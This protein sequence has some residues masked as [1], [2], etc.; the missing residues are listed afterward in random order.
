MKLKLKDTKSVLVLGI[1]GGLAQLTAK[2][3]RDRY[4][5]AKIMGVDARPIE[6]IE[7]D[8]MTFRTMRFTRTNL[9]RLFRQESFD[10]LIV[11]GRM[12]LAKLGSK[13][14]SHVDENMTGISTILDLALEFSVK[15]LV[16]LSTFHVYGAYCDNT[17]FLSE[18]S[19]LR[20][21]IRFPELRDVVAVDHMITSW[22]WKHKKDVDTIL[23]RPCSIIGPNIRNIMS[24][25]LV[26]SMAPA[27]IDYNPLFQ[28]IHEDDM[29]SVICEATRKLPT[30]IYN[31]APPK[32]ITL[33]EAR[34]IMN[35]Q[36][37]PIPVSIVSQFAK[38]LPDQILRIPPY[39]LQYT[40]YQS[41]LDRSALNEFLPEN[42]FKFTSRSALEDYC[43]TSHK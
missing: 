8:D 31:V 17:V 4:P 14:E 3:V 13:R 39:L 10:L 40:K 33:K 2:K 15:K 9:E 16:F 42:F 32:Q 36:S 30:G 37:L 18:D 22:M 27:P 6:G 12:S 19:P 7:C 21:S 1:A 41:L 24:R 26:T 23:L 28:F 34:N 38:L 5:E 43:V 35:V 20:A 11:I 29:S 25:Y